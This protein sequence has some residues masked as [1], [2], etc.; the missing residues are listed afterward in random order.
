M[1]GSRSSEKRNGSKALKLTAIGLSSTRNSQASTG[2]QATGQFYA[3]RRSETF[4]PQLTVCRYFGFPPCR[5][6]NQITKLRPAKCGRRCFANPC[7]VSTSTGRNGK[8][9]CQG[10]CGRKRC[11]ADSHYRTTPLR[12]P[13][14]RNSDGL[15]VGNVTNNRAMETLAAV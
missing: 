12:S 8:Q 6:Q 15:S 11:P 14:Y 10:G 7:R 4:S 1:E 2:K 5:N 3:V 9:K 13:C